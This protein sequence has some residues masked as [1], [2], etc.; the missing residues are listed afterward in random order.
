MGVTVALSLPPPAFSLRFC[1]R[2]AATCETRNVLLVLSDEKSDIFDFNRL[3]SPYARLR[4]AED[5][6]RHGYGNTNPYQEADNLLTLG[7][8]AA[9][10]KQSMGVIERALAAERQ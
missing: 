8:D 9:R 1:F 6:K 5:Q 7:D 10:D 4:A 3:L 2:V